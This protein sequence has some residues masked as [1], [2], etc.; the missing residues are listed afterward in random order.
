MKFTALASLAFV[1]AAALSPAAHATTYNFNM[2]YDGTAL[3]LN[4]GSDAPNGTVLNV[5]DS[6]NISLKAEG[7]NFW[8]VNS[9]YNVLFPLSFLV[10]EAAT[11]AADIATNFLLDGAGVQSTAQT[12]VS[13]SFVHVGAQTFSLASGFD[14]DEVSLIWTLLAIDIGGPSTIVA[15]P[16]FFNGFGQGDAPFVN[17]PKIT[18]SSVSAVPVPAAFPLLLTAVAGMGALSRKRRRDRKAA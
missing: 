14:F 15:G 1:F 12:G 11:R 8:H 2:T 6:F 16:G 10:S 18:Y 17:S 9:D 5:G 4:P 7:T 3:S 13:Q